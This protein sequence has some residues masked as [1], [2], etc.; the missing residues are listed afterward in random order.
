MKREERIAMKKASQKND[1][2]SQLHNSVVTGINALTRALERNELCSVLLDSNVDSIIIK[3]IVS[4][5]QTENVPALLVPFLK[6][7]TLNTI[8]FETAAFALKVYYINLLF[9]L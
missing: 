5:T 8:G 6:A 4:M 7:V 3:H 1:D 9:F 2:V